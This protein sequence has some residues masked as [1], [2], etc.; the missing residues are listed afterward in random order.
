MTEATAA[1]STEDTIKVFA[2]VNLPPYFTGSIPLSYGAS[3]LFYE[4]GDRTEVIDFLNA[5]EPQLAA[6]AAACQP[7]SFGLAQRDVIDESYR[8]ALK[9]D[10]SQFAAQFSPLSSGIMKGIRK[11]LFG[12]QT[13]EDIKVELYKLN[14]YGPGSFFKPHVDTPRGA[15]MV[16][17][18]VVVLPTEHEGGSL[19]IRHREEEFSFDSADAIKKDGLR[20]AHFVAFYSDVEHEVSVVTSGFRVTLTY[21]LHLITPNSSIAPEPNPPELSTAGF[22]EICE[23]LKASLLPLLASPTFLPDGGLIGFG[24][25][26]KY[27]FTIHTEISTIKDYLKGTDV[28]FAKVCGDLGLNFALK[29]A[30]YESDNYS[31]LAKT[32]IL[33]DEFPR[34]GEEVEGGFINAVI[35]KYHTQIAFDMSREPPRKDEKIYEDEEPEVHPNAR[36][37][38]WLKP[39]TARNEV[40]TP[41]ISYGNE[42]S[43][44]YMYGDVCLV[45]EVRRKAPVQ[46]S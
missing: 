16:G 11:A 41:Y 9:M 6:L 3:K 42:A 15:N 17:S 28:A 4:A 1:I 29:A 43:M 13:I 2:D 46:T 20:Q 14:V 35:E 19:L 38:F 25:T 7:A 8:K 21:N 44:D 18:L 45:A 10:S 39:P 12:N 26:H 5:A 23:G 36:P 33:V 32:W 40:E 34:F 24:L 37:T 22:K 31:H 27:P 30:Y